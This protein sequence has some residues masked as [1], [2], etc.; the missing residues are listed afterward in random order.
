MN[1]PDEVLYRLYAV[2]GTLL[3]I[4]MTGRIKERLRSHAKHRPWWDEVHGC[5]LER[6]GS[7]GALIKAERSA[8]RAEKPARNVANTKFKTTSSAKRVQSA[9]CL[10]DVQ[11]DLAQ[12]CEELASSADEVAIAVSDPTTDPVAAFHLADALVTEVQNLSVEVAALRSSI[13]YKIYEA[14]HLTLKALASR[15]GVSVTRA[16]QLVRAGEA[17]QPVQ[18]RPLAGGDPS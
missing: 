10:E 7:R 5:R 11:R 17:Q 16:H 2:D 14:E 4:G 9:C 6:S 3:Y 8:I 15:L 18:D 13:A 1:A 12:V